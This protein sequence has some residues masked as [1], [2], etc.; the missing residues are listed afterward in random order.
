MR[1]REGAIRARDFSVARGALR[2]ASVPCWYHLMDEIG[3]K[4]LRAEVLEQPPVAGKAIAP[5]S[6]KLRGLDSNPQGVFGPQLWKAFRDSVAHVYDKVA[7]PSPAEEARFTLATRSYATPRG[8]LM[9]C[10]GTA[11][12]MTRGPTKAARSADQLVIVLQLEGSV[13]ADSAGRRGRREV[14]DVAISDYARPFHTV[15]T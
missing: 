1:T 9:R 4:D 11:V 14:G 5:P 6:P 15:S 7:L 13:D 8:I 2:R 12:T 3:G 10:A